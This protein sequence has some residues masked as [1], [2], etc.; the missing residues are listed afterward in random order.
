MQGQDEGGAI[1]NIGSVTGL[2]PSPGTAAYGAAKAGLVDLTRTLAVE[3][4]PKVRINC[5]TADLI[6]T[7]KAD[8][9]TAGVDVPLGRMGEA[10]DIGDAV[11]Y[12]ASPRSAYVTGTNL[13]IHGGGRRPAYLGAIAGP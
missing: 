6:A 3:W 12:L 9:A 10:T 5:V 13:V 11:C 1:V 4:A 2:Q 7:E 8:D